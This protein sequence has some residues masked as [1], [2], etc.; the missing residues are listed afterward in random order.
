MSDR[1]RAP[2]GVL[3]GPRRTGDATDIGLPHPARRT[4]GRGTRRPGRTSGKAEMVPVVLSL[5]LAEADGITFQDDPGLVPIFES[6]AILD[7]LADLG[8]D[9]EHHLHVQAEDDDLGMAEGMVQADGVA[10]LRI[11]LAG[12]H[13]EDVPA[14]LPDVGQQLPLGVVLG[15]R[16]GAV[17]SSRGI[18]GRNAGILRHGSC[19]SDS[20]GN[21]GCWKM[22][23]QFS[24]ICGRSLG[25]SRKALSVVEQPVPGSFLV[26]LE[27]QDAAGR[28]GAS[29]SC[30]TAC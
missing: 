29:P 16:Q 23:R 12:T 5:H 21:S 11:L 7:L 13:P 8:D 18:S 25:S 1:R 2:A 14:V 26:Q 15:D 22:N 30:W 19:S 28:S 3:R 17:M 27:S 4:G 9:R 10:E 6:V 20:A 24:R